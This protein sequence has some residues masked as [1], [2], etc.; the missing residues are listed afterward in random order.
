VFRKSAVRPKA[1]VSL[2]MRN[3]RR[4][5]PEQIQGIQR[6]V[7]AS[8]PEMD[9]AA[10][11]VLDQQ[12]VALSRRAEA[13]DGEAGGGLEAKRE[14]EAYL[15]RKVVAVLDKALGPGQGIVSVDVALSPDH[16]KV[17]RE[18]VLGVPGG[19]VVRRREST[20][21]Q[22]LLGGALASTN[23]GLK[24][25]A[26][27]TSE[28]EFQLGRKVEQVV[29]AP[30][31]IRRIS[32]GVLLP[33]HIESRQA[34]SLKEVIAMAVGLNP[35]RGDGIALSW[36]G[37][38]RAPQPAAAEEPKAPPRS[39]AAEPQRFDWWLA[40]AA[41]ALLVATVLLVVLARR[42]PPA[43]PAPLSAKEREEML[44]RLK[45]WTQAG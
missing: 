13:A 6:L 40:L 23:D 12:G 44:N 35:D 16:V 28:V 29:S 2:V 34:E 30:G 32:V 17:T 21:T 33:G 31:G 18:D 9:A 38:A 19:A 24:S 8:V 41:A 14:L 1:S 15:A 5:Q 39:R 3:D 11:T 7:A 22:P 25:P 42:R 43:R 36:V 10:V 26:S 27:T 45:E 37:A 20:Q 4:L